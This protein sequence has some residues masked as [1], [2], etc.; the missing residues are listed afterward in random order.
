[1]MSDCDTATLRPATR[2]GAPADCG[3]GVMSWRDGVM[4]W[5]R[6]GTL[7]RVA[8]FP[9]YRLPFTVYHF[10]AEKAVKNGKNLH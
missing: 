1:M 10:F 7:A 6:S 9:V 3:C 8:P 2:P 5:S 4:T